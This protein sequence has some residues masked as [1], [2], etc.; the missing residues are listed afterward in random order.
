MEVGVDLRMDTIMID[1]VGLSDL[2]D[3]KVST[4][5]RHQR[6]LRYS[7]REA[8]LKIEMSFFSVIFFLFRI[9]ISYLMRNCWRY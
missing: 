2:S 5:C 8:G 3:L 4:A 1:P 6:N 7:F 9:S